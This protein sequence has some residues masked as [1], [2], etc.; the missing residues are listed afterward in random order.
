LQE[1]G[2]VKVDTY[3]DPIVALA[4]FKPHYYDISLID[5]RV[6]NM[7]GFDLYK[8]LKKLDPTIRVCFI[9]AFDVNYQ[10]LQEIFPGLTRECYISKSTTMTKIKDHVH[11]LLQV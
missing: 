6:P 1:A 7:N 10:A 5:V 11:H 4:E 2:E 8:E 9:T 3:N